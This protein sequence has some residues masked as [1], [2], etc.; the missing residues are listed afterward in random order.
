MILSVHFI[1]K[2][3]SGRN[4]PFRVFPAGF[5]SMEGASG[6][7]DLDGGGGESPQFRQ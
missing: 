3:G 2:H 1:G 6:G 5:A 4:N 7:I